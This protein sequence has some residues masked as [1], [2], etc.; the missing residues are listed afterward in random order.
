MEVLSVSLTNF[1]AH[2]D[3]SYD[4]CPGTNAICGANGAG[5]TSI[6]EAIAWVLFDY[7]DYTKA[8]IIHVGAKSAQVGV[9]FVSSLD[10][11]V[12]DVRRCTQ[13]GYEL[14][15]PQLKSLLGVKK[16]E[17]VRRWLCQHLGVP[18]ST[19]LAKLFA[20]TIGIPQGTFT[21]DFLKRAA[22]R[23]KVF[24]PILK[25]E[26]YQQTYQKT[27]DL[28]THAQLQV[29]RLTTLLSE[30]TQALADW[31]LLQQQ[32]TDLQAA[33]RQDQIRFKQLQTQIQ[34]LESEQQ[35][36]QAQV[37]A[38]EN[39]QNQLR[40]LEAQQASKQET[41]A[42]LT[43]S[44]TSAEKAVAICRQQRP[45]FQ[46]YQ[47]AQES[48][49]VIAQQRQQHRDLQ[50][51]HR[52]LHQQL[53]AQQVEQSQL[54]GRLD[55]LA[56]MHESLTHLQKQ[57]PRQAQLEAMLS[58]L[59]AQRQTL[60]GVQIQWQGLQ[61]Q[62]QQRQEALAT[63]QAEIEDLH[64]SQT[65]AQQLSDYEQQWQA[66]QQQLNRIEVTQ[67]FVAELQ[68]LIEP[69]LP[70]R[71]RHWQQVQA[72]LAL[73]ETLP[74]A[75]ADAESLTQ[76][77]H[78]G[79]TLTQ[80]LL[81]IL[82]GL[83]QEASPD[84]LTQLQRRLAQLHAQLQAAQAAQT[85]LASLPIK[86]QQ[87]EAWTQEITSLKQQEAT[88]EVQLAHIPALHAQQVETETA[89]A[90]LNNPRG[91]VQ[92]LK[93]QLQQEPELRSAIAALS[94]TCNT[95][96]QQFNALDQALQTT[97]TLETEAN[98]HEQTLKTHQS[99]YQSYLRH[100]NEANR[101]K[102]LTQ[103]LQT[104]QAE[105][106]H[107]RQ[108]LTDLQA[109]IQAQPADPDHLTQV[110]TTLQHLRSQRDQLQGSLQ[111]QQTQ[112]AHLEQQ[113]QQRQLLATQQ[114]QTQAELEHKQTLLHFI[115]DARR[116]YSQS[117][118]RITQFYLTE[119]SWEAD[120]LFR[121]LLNR[122]DVALAWTQDYE[123]QVQHQGHWRSFK[124]LSGGEQMCAALAIRLALLKVLADIDVAF[125]DEPT[126]NM[127][128]VRR[129]QL[130]EALGNLK[131]FRQL[132][133]ISH[134]DTFE[135]ITEHIIRVDSP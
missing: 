36:L 73:L 124:S 106:D 13:R 87:A 120:R 95:L 7:S 125:F 59:M 74:I 89:L 103:Q 5:K 96:Q 88:L 14:Y 129:Q 81:Q 80:N 86:Q 112:L 50:Q 25:V 29:E 51:Q 45:S 42:L 60:A 127:D 2:R 70:V 77:L 41:L 4:F 98:T 118:P 26:E 107:L 10:G 28:E 114:Q 21:V 38:L 55:M 110:A 16:L 62:R 64:N 102:P 11:R 39:L 83:Y 132:F 63:L 32:A 19:E 84:A 65:Q 97:Q 47:Q 105:F 131:T 18:S 8:E 113:L 135:S 48:L 9:T 58:A 22:E 46:A 52:D 1:K 69:L 20:D 108:H 43:Q 79:V 119:I 17:D 82:E 85:R 61:T 54:Q 126:T 67:Q 101:Y 78:S 115:S 49:Q 57:V 56:P 93:Q 33:L 92:M 117:G 72:A 109:Q 30:Q 90:Q 53:S 123:I 133:V 76:T 23:K 91:Q 34:A 12:Y 128:Q 130:A 99:A 122:Q 66:C 71:D 3:R 37:Q 44:W 111:P 134:D 35:Q 121:E 27:R 24:D 75:A 31:P 116:I 68:T 15:D 100:R 6:L 104:A 94:Q 40:Q